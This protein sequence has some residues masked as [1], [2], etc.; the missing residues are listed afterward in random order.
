VPGTGGVTVG[1]VAP[2]VPRDLRLAPDRLAQALRRIAVLLGKPD[3]DLRGAF[4]DGFRHPSPTAA[5]PP[6][7]TS[8]ALRDGMTST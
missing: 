2:L 3:A 5:R 8:G 1:S 7:A 6:P 4:L